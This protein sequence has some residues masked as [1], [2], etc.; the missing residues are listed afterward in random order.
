MTRLK[1]ATRLSQMK[2]R[3]RILREA[4]VKISLKKPPWEKE[5]SDTKKDD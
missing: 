2:N 4:K 3:E 5:K 1:K